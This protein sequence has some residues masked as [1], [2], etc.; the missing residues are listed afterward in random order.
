[1]FLLLRGDM[2]SQYVDMYGEWVQTEVDLFKTLLPVDGVCIEVGS[3][4]GMH[5]IP[6]S[7][8][9]EKGRVYCYEPQR[10]IFHILC[11]NIALNNRIN[12]VA[13]NLAVGESP[14]RIEVQSSDYDEA[15]NYGS[16]SIASGFSTENVFTG[17]VRT[18][19][20]DVVSLDEDPELADLARVD[21]LKIDAEGFEPHILRGARKLI[22]RHKPYLFVE[23]NNARIVEEMVPEIQAHGYTGYWF[24]ASRFRQDNYNR[25]GFATAGW[26]SNLIFR[27]AERP[28]LAGQLQP[29]QEYA[30]LARG[31]PVL[32]QFP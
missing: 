4:I 8:I 25:S 27:P 10:P 18:E 23:A 20:V 12:V 13:R 11:G 5:A 21:F 2:I 24:V 1:M 22:A 9:C 16:F 30:D 32:S 15:W 6:L 29:F 14:A 7:R 19:K 26:D 31:V 17:P 3:N 28:A